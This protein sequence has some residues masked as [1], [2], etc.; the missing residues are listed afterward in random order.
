M[1]I[2]SLK[3]NMSNL[4]LEHN[5]ANKHFE[6]FFKFA[7][8]GIVTA[9][10][11]GNI[12]FA[13]PYVNELFGYQEDELIGKNI[14]I[15]IPHRLHE[16]HENNIKN[17]FS[18]PTNR[19]MGKGSELFGIKKDNSELKIEISLS[20]YEIENKTFALAF[21]TDISIR[22]KE[23]EKL[24]LQKSDLETSNKNRIDEIK[25]SNKVL[26]TLNKKLE[27]SIAYQHSIIDNI[28]VMIFLINKKG[29]ITY[30][31][32]EAQKI[33]GYN[34]LEIV[35][36]KSID[37]FFSKAEMK[38]CRAMLT[39]NKLGEY[40]SDIEV[41][42]KMADIGKI[43]NLECKIKTSKNKH[44]PASISLS[45]IVSKRDEKKSYGYLAVAINISEQK[46][47]END[48]ITS[49]EKEKDLSVLKS[50]FVSMASHEF[51]TPLSTI[52]S[53]AFIINKY[54]KT[55]EQT[56]REK[57]INRIVNSVTLM[58]DILN[59]FL[60]LG[61]IEEGKI[62]VK[63][64]D[65]EMEKYMQ[66]IIQDLNQH[67]KNGQRIQYD[68]IGSK[69]AHLDLNLLKNIVYNLITNAIKFS[70][71]SSIIKVETFIDNTEVKLLVKDEGI[72]IP[73]N[74]KKHMMDRFF[75]ASN[76]TNI[77]GTG[78]GMHIVSKYVERMNGHLH[79]ESTLN[80]GTTFF[81]T[82]NKIF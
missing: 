68:H 19:L 39:S 33:T 64:E 80:M 63:L 57:H 45:P 6:S 7:S 60:N 42:L 20:S 21:I 65:F 74:E 14:S 35:E 82:F 15:L 52:L 70:P 67:T 24:I 31:N 34:K 25:R 48:L 54:I 12:V 8:I 30:F 58:T 49:L 66:T 13:N 61:K 47:H 46:K 77:Q 56:K 37:Y 76:A 43:K 78:L 50:R 36:K 55:E 72:G 11:R 44:I 9:D 5:I 18:H 1:L 4:L 41:V 62:S 81:I 75:R 17:Y 71:E 26:E 23:S 73:E 29:L 16:Q 69:I 2:N 53:S 22:S 28:Q 59:E 32:P 79:F 27:T 3:G 10:S 51:R 40:K 38:K